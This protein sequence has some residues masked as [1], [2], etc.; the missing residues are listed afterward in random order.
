MHKFPK[1]KTEVLYPLVL[2]ICVTV[3]YVPTFSGDFILDD[4]HLLK[5]NL[6]IR[7]F[8]SPASYLSHEDGVGREAPPGHHTGY[9]RPLVP[10]FYT[11][12]HKIWGMRAVGFRITNLILHLTTC[13]LLYFT[14]IR[15]LRDPFASFLTALLFGLHP[16]NTESVAWISSRNNILVALFSLIS[17]SA[18]IKTGN[19]RRVGAKVVSYSSFAAA[20]LCKEFAILLLPVFFLY[21][22]LIGRERWVARAEVFGYIPFLL[23][24]FFYFVLRA[25]AIGSVL[26]P[27]ST[28]SLWKSIYFVPFLIIYNL[29]LILIPYGLHSFI[30]QY[31]DTYV[32]WKAVAGFLGLALLVFFLWKERENKILLFSI[33]AFLLALF[34]VL[35]IIHTSAVTLI[36]MR[37]LYFPMIFLSVSLAWYLQRLLSINRHLVLC[38]FVLM[39]IYLGTYSYLL[40]RNLWQNEDAFYEE[41]VLHF[42]NDF[43]AG[44]LAE[45]L[46]VKKNFMEAERYFQKAIH[47]YPHN[48]RNY[49]NYAA[50]LIDTKREDEAL[51]YLDKA[52]AL[53]KSNFEKGQWFNNRGMA[54]FQLGKK[55]KGLAD[56]L[57]AVA[58]WPHEAQFWSNLGGAYGTLGDY[59]H[60]I[61]S[62]EK[63]LEIDPDSVELRKNLALTHMKVGNYEKAI[64]TLERIPAEQREKSEDIS[65]LLGRARHE[66]LSK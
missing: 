16:V 40:N 60:S 20:L 5:D 64:K 48:L 27:L 18:Y 3:V 8:K 12:E 31:P 11:L 49:L 58:Y 2:C 34:P 17:F 30:I 42:S 29:K 19:K 45:R 21:N 55:E 24:L 13:I 9:Y 51:I 10:L 14:F 37:W 6:F 46:F 26:T 36:S 43:Y 28:P 25:H 39:V 57:E 56:F 50:L 54:Y 65:A 44:G 66:L 7:E 41:E 53:I 52:K 59:R 1:S 38:I 22:R 23:I 47:L 61:A 32:S 63:G 62:L 4:R 33:V 35:N 15:L